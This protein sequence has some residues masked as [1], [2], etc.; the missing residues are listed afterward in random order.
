M[1]LK[2]GCCAKTGIGARCNNSL[3]PNRSEKTIPPHMMALAHAVRYPEAGSGFV[4]LY[5]TVDIASFPS[6]PVI[7]A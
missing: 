4:R 7:V 2:P 5:I 1:G 3:D 6:Q